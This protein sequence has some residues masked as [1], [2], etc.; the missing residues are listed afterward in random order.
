MKK[1]YL[2]LF[3]LFLYLFL[4]VW[5]TYSNDIVTNTLWDIAYNMDSG[6]V[7]VAEVFP[8]D[9]WWVNLDRHPFVVFF[10]SPFV[11][12]FNKIFNSTVFGLLLVQSLFASLSVCVVN[13][14]LNL[15]SDK[16]KINFLLTLIY[17]FSYTLLVFSSMPEDY[18]YIT[19]F[20]ALNL[21]YIIKILKDETILKLNFKHIF[22][23][24]FLMFLCFLVAQ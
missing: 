24:S 1:F 7:F 10:I 18:I 11:N 23:L 6:K 22:I 15:I 5:L 4:G 20:S 9:R 3:F 14:I 8:F 16:T 12:L 21:F 19:F 13:S 2:F 17:G